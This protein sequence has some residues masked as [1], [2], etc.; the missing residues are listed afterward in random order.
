[1]DAPRF[2]G[3]SV[4]APRFHGSSVDGPLFHGSSVD[5][6][7][8]LPTANGFAPID[9][10]AGNATP[11]AEEA[12]RL[13]LL[14]G[15]QMP[16]SP[17]VAALYA[18]LNGS[19]DDREALSKALAGEADWT[20]QTDNDARALM[21]AVPPCL[22]DRTVRDKVRLLLAG[23]AE[24]P[25][26]LPPRGLALRYSEFMQLL[27][28][29][30]A[31]IAPQN[32]K[33]D[34][35][36]S[37]LAR[38]TGWE[39]E[40]T[41]PD[42]AAARAVGAAAV[43]TFVLERANGRAFH[44]DLKAPANHDQGSGPAKFSLPPPG[45][46]SGLG[47]AGVVNTLRAHGCQPLDK[48]A[49]EESSEMLGLTSLSVLAPATRV[50]A[51]MSPGIKRVDVDFA[52]SPRVP[53]IE[54]IRA[55]MD[56]LPA[57]VR[58][59]WVFGVD[60]A[61]RTVMRDADGSAGWRPKPGCR[62]LKRCDSPPPILF[63]PPSDLATRPGGVTLLRF[64]R[65][66]SGRLTEMPPEGREHRIDLARA[67]V[68]RL[69]QSIQ[70]QPALLDELQH[71]LHDVGAC[72]D[73]HLHCLAGMDLAA[74]AGA[75]RTCDEAAG[76]LLRMALQDIID[77]HVGIVSAHDPENLEKAMALRALLDRRLAA[78]T[79]KTFDASF[80]PFYTTLAGMNAQRPGPDGA[81][82][83]DS[84]WPPEMHALIDRLI[85]D[86]VRAGFPAVQDL[87]E[88]AAG[89]GRR[90]AA[91][92]TDQPLYQDA[93]R[94]WQQ[95][96]LEAETDAD[97]ADASEADRS[98]YRAIQVDMPRELRAQRLSLMDSW[99]SPLREA[100]PDDR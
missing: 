38:L 27:T 77:R 76:V 75:A 37:R 18:R 68:Q 46:V 7:S 30:K 23:W 90:A 78:I 51:L 11:D 79:G 84:A 3:S 54:T 66:L 19:Y 41:A 33:A 85:G 29:L 62:C 64:L 88:D 99:L 69:L 40:P 61:L 10:R 15:A 31:A 96:F 92:L 44:L 16:H 55:L 53:A 6:L 48:R 17:D 36:R 71:H 57:Q 24:R 100:F 34:T 86:E 94:T 98:A 32:L 43:R 97:R 45:E 35:L 8:P 93:E 63:D 65:R 39:T 14:T 52:R 56:T 70:G 81:P 80:T 22:M 4:D 91:Q 60:D 58:Q 73:Q 89:P 5:A 95:R 42:E 9:P 74:S 59:L 1:M 83:D 49:Y 67:R 87:L 82:L 25:T 72:V 50:A 12:Q 2:H 47:L 20:A 26:A 21:A 28:A 13:E